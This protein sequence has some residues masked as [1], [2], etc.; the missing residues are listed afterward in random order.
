MRVARKTFPELADLRSA[1]DI[2][3]SIEYSCSERIETIRRGNDM[4]CKL[5]IVESRDE[6]RKYR[7]VMRD[8][9]A[10]ETCVRKYARVVPPAA[11]RAVYC[12]CTLRQQ[13]LWDLAVA[14]F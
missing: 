3:V 5:D 12:A 14:S 2:E 13:N 11:W 4:E 8:E 1:L 9:Y 6:T 10:G 7:N